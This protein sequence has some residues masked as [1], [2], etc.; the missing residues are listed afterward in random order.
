MNPSFKIGIILLAA[1]NS[2]RLGQPK[3]LVNYQQQPLL[4]HVM[5]TTYPFSFGRRVLILGAQSETILSQIETDEYDVIINENWKE[6][7]A[8]SIRVGLE[9]L[10]E[11]SGIT[12]VLILLSDQPYVTQKIISRL[13]SSHQPGQITACEYGETIGVPAIFSDRYF[14][15]LR[16]LKGDQGAKKVILRHIQ[17]VAAVPFPLGEIDIDKPEDLEKL[18]KPE[19][20]ENK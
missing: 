15:E 6:G 18:I 13:I 19:S 5:N 4:Q 16:N 17:R 1:G 11:K 12:E 14:P 20:R 9:T 7:I 8:S 3:Q 10:M 2:R